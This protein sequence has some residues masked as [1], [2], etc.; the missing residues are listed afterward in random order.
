MLGVEDDWESVGQ[1]THD[2]DLIVLGRP[3]AFE[4]RPDPLRYDELAIVTVAIDEVL[5]GH[6]SVAVP[7]QLQVTAQGSFVEDW[8]APIPATPTL[9]F[10]RNLVGFEERQHI[11]VRVGDEFI[12]YVPGIHQNVIAELG[13]RVHVPQAR[14]MLRWYGPDFFPLPLHGTSFERLLEQ[15]RHNAGSAGHPLDR[16]GVNRSGALF[17]C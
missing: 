10:L 14:R 5:K 15:V 13:G 1:M 3:V 11:E 2:V 9:F 17:A 12:Y 4:R 16:N 6:P 8:D 7:G